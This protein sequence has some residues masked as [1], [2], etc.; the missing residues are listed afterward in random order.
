MKI[1]TIPYK[2]SKRKLLENISSLIPSNSKTFFDGF[3]GTGIVSAYMRSKGYRVSANDTSFSS[4]LYGKVFLSGFDEKLV[5]NALLEMNNLSGKEG[6]ITQSYS[7][8][9][10]RVIRG[11]G[12]K[13]ETRPLGFQRKNAIKIDEVRDWIENNIPEGKNK[14][15][16]I[17]SVILAANKVFNNPNDQKSVLKEWTKPSLEDIIFESPTLISGIEG[18]QYQKDIFNNFGSYDIVY[19]DPPYTSGVLYPACYHLNDSIAIWDKPEVDKTY[20]IPRPN[21]AIFQGDKKGAPFYSKKSSSQ[22]FA[23]LLTNFKDSG[24]VIV[25]YSNA[26][27]NSISIEELYNIATS[28]GEVKVYERDHKICTQFKSMNKVSKSLKEMFVV[29]KPKI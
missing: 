21:R 24:C 9:I 19:L 8:E 29:L 4:A 5:K 27:R 1:K 18:K 13:K 11:T 16:L 22:V 15:A 23:D 12:G 25:S 2:G 26:P 10:E 20:A 6:W 14:N 28:L 7:G 17:F 3:S